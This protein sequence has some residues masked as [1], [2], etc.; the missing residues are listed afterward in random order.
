MY[1]EKFIKYI[2]ILFIVDLIFKSTMRIQWENK[3]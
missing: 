2:S 1:I 3:K